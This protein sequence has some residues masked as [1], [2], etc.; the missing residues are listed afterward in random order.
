VTPHPPLAP[1]VEGYAGRLSYEPGEELTLHLAADVPHRSGRIARAT[2]ALAVDVEI[3]RLGATRDVVARFADVVAE[4]HGIPSDAAEAGARW[5]ATLTVP[6]DERWRSGWYDVALTATRADG[7]TVV[8]HAGFVVRAPTNQPRA[9]ILL[10]L[11]TNTWNA[12]NDWGGPNLYTGGHHVSFRRPFAQGLLERPDAQLHRNAVTADEP[13]L[14]GDAW[15]EHWRA[16]NIC[17]WSAC[18]GWPTWEGPFVAWAEAH[19]YELDYAVNADLEER[20]S[21][22]HSYPLVL[23][24]GHDEYWS[25]P[26]RD[27]VEGYIGDGGNVAFLS[28][29]T[30]FWQV[31]LADGGNTMIGY[32]DAARRLDPLRKERPELL[33]SIWSDPI[34]GRPET[35]MTGVSFSRGGYARI[36]GGTPRGQR[37]YTVWRPEHCATAT[38]SVPRTPWSATSATG[39]S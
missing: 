39:A 11:A 26:M 22:V 21:I 16:E 37:G 13:D 3:A 29:N 25:S 23:S 20:P 36:A 10:Q 19:G 38:C 18:A 6:V 17:S 30:S 14:G 24:V 27:T 28:G 35:Q 34:V 4:P 2:D 15:A 9:R 5:P 33:T 12:Y 8:R 1:A 32:K 31:R 7:T